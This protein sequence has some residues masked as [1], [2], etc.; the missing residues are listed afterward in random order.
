[1]MKWLSLFVCV[2]AVV[3]YSG[4]LCAENDAADI[5]ALAL[6]EMLNETAPTM[7]SLDPVSAPP[8]DTPPMAP[9]IPPASSPTMLPPYGNPMAPS[10]SPVTT[11]I[12]S[13][14]VPM[15]MTT[16]GPVITS[17][18]V[19]TTSP[20]SVIVD[21]EDQQQPT[22]FWAGSDTSISNDNSVSIQV[23]GS[24]DKLVLSYFVDIYLKWN[25][26]NN[27]NAMNSLS[28]FLERLPEGP[29]VTTYD[30]AVYVENV[31][32]WDETTVSSTNRQGLTYHKTEKDRLT[33][34]IIDEEGLAIS[35]DKSLSMMAHAL[36]SRTLTLRVSIMDTG[37]RS[38]SQSSTVSFYSRESGIGAPTVAM[39]FC[40]DLIVQTGEECDQGPLG[41]PACTANCTWYR[42]SMNRTVVEIIADADPR[43]MAPTVI[44][45][46]AVTAGA[47]TFL[48]LYYNRKQKQEQIKY[49]PF[50]GPNAL[51]PN[52][53]VHPERLAQLE[54]I[55]VDESNNYALAVAVCR[56]A[57]AAE[58][59]HTAKALSF[60]FQANRCCLDLL[61]KLVS[62]EVQKTFQETTLFRQD[63]MASKIMGSYSNII[64]ASYLKSILEPVL[65]PIVRHNIRCEVETLKL[66]AEDN[67]DANRINLQA[68]CEQVFNAI[69]DQP[70]RM[71]QQIQ[72]LCKMLR[73]NVENKFPNSAYK[74]I[75]AFLFLRFI[76]PSVLLSTTN[77]IV[78]ARNLTATPRALMLIARVLTKLANEVQFLPHEKD[79]LFMNEFLTRNLPKLHRFYDTVTVVMNSP[80]DV[81]IPSAAKDQGLISLYTHI[82]RNFEKIKGSLQD[83]TVVEEVKRVLSK[84][85][86]HIFLDDESSYS[87]I[88]ES[89]INDSRE[90]LI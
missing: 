26:P 50:R 35:L 78:N 57:N 62:L 84:D 83:A 68:L 24:S 8:I 36:D 55:L 31:G 14:Q 88:P 1:M 60:V 12:D 11:P 22:L 82:E 42:D 71:P 9:S 87:A 67:V 25:I 85:E 66:D 75:G 32:D 90:R 15:E 79:F 21:G 44:V 70:Q 53:D 65:E 76:S 4:V 37:K 34:C 17:P 54:R 81:D 69:V 51:V 38:V 5:D 86:V 46:A 59:D 3:S 16:P 19:G 43:I 13:S 74:S 28:L 64:G 27:V 41:G 72:Q 6:V 23:N 80:V 48:I 89:S 45:I 40:G 30:C 2:I 7:V 73:T 56:A 49:K 33:M 18:P 58:M 52:G 63:S 10:T 61:E 39:A 20:L 47:I 77:G 29:P